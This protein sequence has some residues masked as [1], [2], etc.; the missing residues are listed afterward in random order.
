[1]MNN[2][3]EVTPEDIRVALNVTQEQADK[4]FDTIDLDVVCSAAYYEQTLEEQTVAV[5]KAIRQEVEHWHVRR[6]DASETHY[7]D[8]YQYTQEAIEKA[9][10]NEEIGNLISELGN[11]KTSTS[12]HT[13]QTH[14]G[15]DY[16]AIITLNASYPVWKA[17]GKPTSMLQFHLVK[18][19][20]K[21]GEATL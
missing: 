21:T 16:H 4:I 12:N 19:C 2:F 1:M 3:F 11:G 13:I 6:V 14:R 10:G 9:L 18:F 20:K 15:L 5:H 7:A 17:A 8:W